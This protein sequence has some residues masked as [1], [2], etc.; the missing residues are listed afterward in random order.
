MQAVPT[1]L[2][3]SPGSHVVVVLRRRC[4]T[5]LVLANQLFVVSC[6]AFP[7]PRPLARA[8]RRYSCASPPHSAT[9]LHGSDS[10]H[11]SVHKLSSAL[12][13]CMH[14]FGEPL[15]AFAPGNWHGVVGSS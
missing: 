1:S 4:Q 9:E 6:F 5:G 2:V 3:P 8:R 14:T 10:V 13:T 11:E 12:L 7:S 15:L